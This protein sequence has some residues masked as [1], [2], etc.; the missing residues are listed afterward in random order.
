MRSRRVC[1]CQWPRATSSVRISVALQPRQVS[2]KPP[3]ASSRPQP[4]D[5]LDSSP[6][7]VHLDCSEAIPSIVPLSWRMGL[8]RR[9]RKTCGEVMYVDHK[10]SG[11]LM[12]HINC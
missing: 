2:L 3:S 1:S 6:Q 4:L 10:A 7:A 8:I 9:I 5:I 11:A 12:L